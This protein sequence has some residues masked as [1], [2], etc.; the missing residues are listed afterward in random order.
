MFYVTT[1]FNIIVL[2]G[3]TASQM[4]ITSETSS[5]SS[6]MIAISSSAVAS[7]STVVTVSDDSSRITADCTTKPDV[8]NNGGPSIQADT[9]TYLASGK[10]GEI[11]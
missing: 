2:N 5:S 11:N 10:L 7:S 8:T 3:H 4:T 6:L 1:L 9:G